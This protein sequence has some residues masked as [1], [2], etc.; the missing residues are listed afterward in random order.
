MDEI[1]LDPN[2]FNFM[3]HSFTGTDTA[4]FVSLRIHDGAAVEISN[5]FGTRL[6]SAMS[7]ASPPFSMS[8]LEVSE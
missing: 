5:T 2:P 6:A 1:Q 8:S 7:N 3:T 4:F